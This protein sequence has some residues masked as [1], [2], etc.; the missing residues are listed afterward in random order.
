MAES[1]SSEMFTAT[2]KDFVIDDFPVCSI[3]V[4]KECDVVRLTDQ[5]DNTDKFFVVDFNGVVTNGSAGLLPA[6][7]LITVVDDAGTP[8]NHSD[9][10]VIPVNIDKPLEVGES[11]PFSGKFFCNENPPHNTI[12]ASFDS[13]DVHLQASYNVTCS[14]LPLDPN[15]SLSK[16]CWTRLKTIDSL[17]AVEV[18]FTGTVS[19]CGNV[20]LLVT[21]TDDK[22]GGVVFGPALIKPGGSNP[23]TGSY[24]PLSANG[25][26]NMPCIAVFSDTFTAEANSP[27]PGVEQKSVKVTANCPLCDNC[28]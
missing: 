25:D 9:D 18:F 24:L 28:D 2:L 10:V 23:I 3:N 15:L 21:V 20:P 19:N 16:L 6:P 14:N 27:L 5:N 11:V 4:S 1:R 17:L 13:L 26:V 12:D 22:A 8:N 7:A